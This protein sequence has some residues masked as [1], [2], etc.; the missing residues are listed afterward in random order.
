MLSTRKT[1]LMLGA[2]AAVLLAGALAVRAQDT[3]PPPAETPPAAA[4]AEGAAPAPAP[5]P[6]RNPDDVVATV[7][8]QSITEA[9]VTMAREQFGSEL[10]QVPEEQQRGMLIDALVNL[11]LLAQ[12]ARE[13]GIDK[14]PDFPRK[15][16]FLEMQAL[17]NDYVEKNVVESLT[18]DEIQQ[19]YQA[20]VVANHKPEEQVHARHILVDT[21]EAA[22][23][24]IADLKAGKSFEELA[25]QSK[26]PSGENG[27]DLGFFGKGQMV[28]PFEEAAFAL[29]PGKYT[30][31]PVQSEFGWHVIKVEEKKMSEPPPFEEVEEQ[32]R[33]H[34]MRQKFDGLMTSLR[35][36]YKVEV[37]GAPAAD[38]A[39][40]DATAP[41]GDAATPEA[42]PAPEVKPQ[43]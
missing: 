11:Q 38:P 7:G 14:A 5:E 18:P 13:E 8:E 27:G 37:V 6:A 19:G 29:E 10:A 23:K 16:A 42:A 4:P 36:K 9:D 28:P 17:R 39:A 21:K 3:V 12:A 24:I 40:P 20:M 30:E 43:N 33:N 1:S 2:A 22:E 26:D 34:L 31:T 41:E 25:K 35:E 32:L 15:V